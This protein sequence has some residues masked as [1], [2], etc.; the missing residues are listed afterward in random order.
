LTT[1]ENIN[2]FDSQKWLQWLSC[3][4][5]MCTAWI[6]AVGQAKL[7]RLGQA[8]LDQSHSLTTAL[9]WPENLESHQLRPRL[10]HKV[11]WV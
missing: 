9:A 8:R 4:L 3:G 1:G 7:A 5:V 11:F 6:Q 10:S 2:V